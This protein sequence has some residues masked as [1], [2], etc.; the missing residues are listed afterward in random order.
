[1][2]EEEAAHSMGVSL[3]VDPATLKEIT[4]QA[5][6]KTLSVILGSSISHTLR[7]LAAK[8]KEVE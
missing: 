6:G 7:V 2:Q 3:R 1:M 5:Q 8:A 4:E